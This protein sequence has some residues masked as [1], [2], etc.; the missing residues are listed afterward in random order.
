VSM[1]LANLAVSM[2][3]EKEVLYR[4]NDS[5]KF[6]HIYCSG[7]WHRQKGPIRYLTFLILNLSDTEPIW[8][9][10]FQIPNLSVPNLSDTE[11]W[12]YLIT[13]FLIPNMSD[14]GP[15][16]PWTFLILGLS[17]S[18]PFWSRTYLIPNL[19]DGNLLTIDL[20]VSKPISQEPI[21][22]TSNLSDTDL[23]DTEPI[24][25]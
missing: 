13:T 6:W 23:F 20:S 19:S 8:S 22:Q 24:R 10:T 15:F 2:I 21:Y 18:E 4:C 3:P 5:A 14:S 12:T 9:L 7:Q 11:Y 1:I 17:D 16:L 25:Y